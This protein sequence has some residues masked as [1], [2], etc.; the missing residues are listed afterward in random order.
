MNNHPMF[1]VAMMGARMHYAVPRILHA[2]EALAHFYTDICAA[3]DWPRALR[4]IPPALLPSGLR[5]LAGR[6]PRDVPRNLITAFPRF[7]LE[8]QRR[9]A[10]ARTVSEMT[11]LHLWAGETFN[12]LILGASPP[13]QAALY[14]FN[15]AG[16]DLL[17]AWRGNGW[18][19]FLEQTIAPRRVEE[20]ILREEEAA[21]PGW[22][23]P[24]QRDEFVGDCEAREAAEWQEADCILCGSEFVREGIR[25]C[26][27]PAERCVV[28]PYG[29]ELGAFA[30]GARPP[31]RD[32]PLRVLTVGQISLRKGAHYVL[33]AARR[34]LGWAVFRMVGPMEFL[35]RRA[36]ELRRHVEWAGIVP[37]PEIQ[38]HYQ[39]ADVFL[40]PSLCE[41][42][43]TVTYEA[44]AAGL[45]VVTTPNTGSI[46]ED[47][48]SGFVIPARDVDAIVQALERLMND[49]ARLE[50]MSQAARRRAAEGSLEAY[51]KRLLAA[52]RV[53]G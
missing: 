38:R 29:I 25:Q 28:V 17:R 46:V 20:R 24:R 35:P 30:A 34:L 21:F 36:E 26:G 4:M 2:A 23:Q 12:R 33:E 22:Q 3:R 11:A 6:V 47:A 37:R 32:R 49:A 18:P 41:G 51:A 53:A 13:K 48:S 14:C 7:G 8:Y 31:F 44:L 42:S 15:T 10:S 50:A 19:T 43:A 5:R 45:P 39:W 27:G 1:L 9:R 52:L 16:L 40:L